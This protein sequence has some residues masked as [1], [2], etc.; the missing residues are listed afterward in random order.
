MIRYFGLSCV[1]A[2]LLVGLLLVITL[3]YG[4]TERKKQAQ[5]DG[6]I[7]SSVIAYRGKLDNEYE[8]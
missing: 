7:N 1:V 6:I 8:L 3:A 4:I 2:I 5:A